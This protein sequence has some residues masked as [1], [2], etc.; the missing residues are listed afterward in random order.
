MDICK[1]EATPIDLSKLSEV[2]KNEFDKKTV[3]DQLV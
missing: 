1:L 3:Y 2:V